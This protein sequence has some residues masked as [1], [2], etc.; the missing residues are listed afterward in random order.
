MQWDITQDGFREA[1]DFV[2]PISWKS[3]VTSRE[4][5]NAP[6]VPADMPVMRCGL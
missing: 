3:C 4:R 1:F 6:Q 2:L 5:Q